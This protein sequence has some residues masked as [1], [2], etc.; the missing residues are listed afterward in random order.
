MPVQRRAPASR[1]QAAP[2]SSGYRGREALRRMDEEIESQAARREAA[3]LNSDMP[4]R[5]FCPVGETR[6]IVVVDYSLEEVFF[7]HEH[8]LKNK[9]SGKWDIFCACINENA[10]CPV[11]TVAERPSYW[12]MYLTVID[13]TPY[14]NKDD[15]EVPW[16]KKLLVVKVQQ[17]KKIARLAERNG[18]LRGMVLS[19]T[20]DSDKDAS[21]GGDIEFVEFMSEEDLLA[22]E[23]DYEYTDSQNHR[24]TKHINGHEPFD[25]DALFPMPTEQQLRAIVGGRPEA[26]SRDEEHAAGVRRGPRRSRGDGF[27][28][29]PGTAPEPRRATASRRPA[30]RDEGNADEPGE[31]APPPRRTAPTPQRSATRPTPSRARQEQEA[32]PE[33]EA[34]DDDAVDS[35]PPPRRAAPPQ[36]PAARSAPQRPTSRMPVRQPQPDP[37]AEPE[38]EDDGSAA[39]PSAA[40]I[41]ER[42]RQ[43]RSR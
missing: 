24:K 43:L 27:D 21:I 20:R 29:D 37:E 23:T 30:A 14:V 4:F 39:R 31:D 36:R 6:E 10:N 42:R 16:S 8:N 25:Y 40:S 2:Q 32:E 19:M 11:C 34:Y 18:G 15:V 33:E 9:R 1:Q 17:Q 3:K 5:F 12:A 38:V 26:G 13:L 7:R 22:Y 28:D 41:A 35:D